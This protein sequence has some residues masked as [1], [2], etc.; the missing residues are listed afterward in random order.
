[1]TYDEFL[2]QNHDS[3]VLVALAGIFC[4]DKESMRILRHGAA[5][6]GKD[7][8]RMVRDASRRQQDCTR[9]R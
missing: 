4:G 9:W 6:Y 5:H 7:T 8:L 2:D 3:L 1:M